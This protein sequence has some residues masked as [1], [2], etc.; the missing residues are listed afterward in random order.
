MGVALNTVW[1]LGYWSEK[2]SRE[3]LPGFRHLSDTLLGLGHEEAFQSL[4]QS[5]QET[6]NT[7]SW[8]WQ[9]LNKAIHSPCQKRVGQ[10]GDVE[11]HH[12]LNQL[13]SLIIVSKTLISTLGIKNSKLAAK[14]EKSV[15]EERYQTDVQTLLLQVM[16][17]TLQLRIDF[18]A[19]NV[20]CWF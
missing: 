20:C 7:E 2:E 10:D 4:R 18:C 9:R 6:K 5:N 12:I 15:S 19:L 16:V 13:K 17:S 11:Q 3:T 1:R 14:G 8:S